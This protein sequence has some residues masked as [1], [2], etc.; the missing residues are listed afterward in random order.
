[1]KYETI[2]HSEMIKFL[3]VILSLHYLFSI[4]RRSLVV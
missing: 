4:C 2:L 3:I 1:M